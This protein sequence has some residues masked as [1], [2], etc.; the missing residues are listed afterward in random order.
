MRASHCHSLKDKRALIRKLEGRVRARYHIAI[1]EVGAQDVWQRLIIGFAIVGSDRV[2]VER[3][4][5]DVVRF[6]ES[7]GLARLERDD[8]ELI[9]YG[10]DAFGDDDLALRDL[11]LTEDAD[12]TGERSFADEPWIPDS[13]KSEE[14]P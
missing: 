3:I 14:T 8:H 7:T 2:A 10:A 4:S 6:I 13:W 12:A 1:A 9:A 11:G 5:A